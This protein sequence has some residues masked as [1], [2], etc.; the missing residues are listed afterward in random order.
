MFE[1]AVNFIG[2]NIKAVLGGEAENSAE[3]FRA[4]EEARGIVGRVDVERAR[5][6]TNQGFESRQVVGPAVFGLAAPF[7]DGSP[8]AFGNSQRA[9][10]AGSFDDG[11]VL[12]GEQRVIEEEDGFFGGGDNDELIWANGFIDGD[13]GFAE[14][15]GPRRFG[16][17][18][19]VRGR[20]RERRVRERGV[21]RW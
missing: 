13:E 16:V 6:G 20:R 19:P 3:D 18:A 8:G 5:V 12:R 10:V 15:G 1:F 17:A 11:V 21:P 4:H 7:T 14:P 2:K 9:F